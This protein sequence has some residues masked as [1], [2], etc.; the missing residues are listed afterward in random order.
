ML[1]LLNRN[2][3]PGAYLA[4]S[5]SNHAEALLAAN[6]KW[7]RAACNDVV[8]IRKGVAV[9]LSTVRK[10]LQG[11][12]TP[13]PGSELSNDDAIRLAEATF[14]DKPWCLVRDWVIYDT[15]VEAF[16][17][18][19]GRGLLP[20]RVYADCVILDRQCRWESGEW[21]RSSPLKSFTHGCLFETENTVYVLLGDG[22]RA[23]LI[24]A[25]NEQQ[26]VDNAA[27]DLQAREKLRRRAFRVMANRDQR[28]QALADLDFIERLD[29][30]APIGEAV[31][32]TL[33]DVAGYV[34]VTRRNDPPLEVV[35]PSDIPE[36]W[37]NRMA[38]VS[39]DVTMAS[40]FPGYYIDDWREF[41][42][43][44]RLEHEQLREYRLDRADG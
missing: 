5:S 19:V 9:Q 11:G 22:Y 20:T 16:T 37:R 26:L 14:P 18:Y 42:R 39:I 15:P 7:Q 12:A 23:G 3:L 1:F 29:H 36:P 27:T 40:N 35:R 25:P 21:V 43:L 4:T 28:A 2:D 13:L 34:P 44:W 10:F 8:G 32:W 17:T 31:T 41:L 33:D 38:A 30:E 24:R 6:P